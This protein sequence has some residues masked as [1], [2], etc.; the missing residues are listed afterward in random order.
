V[1]TGTRG[2][3]N[4]DGDDGTLEGV[5]RMKRTALAWA[6]GVKTAMWEFPHNLLIL[7]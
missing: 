3:V 5:K 4:G 2:R 6:L 7:K 1:A